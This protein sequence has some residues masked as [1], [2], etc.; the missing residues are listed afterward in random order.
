VTVSIRPATLD[1]ADAIGLVTEASYR[2]HVGDH[3]Y[4]AELRDA[5]P[6]IRDAEVLVATLSDEVVG[7]VVLARPGSPYVETGRADELE[8]RMLAVAEA[9]RGQ[10]IGARLMDAVEARARDL[11][12][13]AVV[14]ST[15][16]T[17]HAAHRLYERRGY[18]RD[19]ARDWQPEPGFT[20]LAY[21]LPLD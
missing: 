17:M 8:V 5:G 3:E 15:A 20:L 14:L 6:R 10:G 18:T 16:P 12:C 13:T 4:L 19:P 1:D 9:V 2:E 11:D 21:R 7:S